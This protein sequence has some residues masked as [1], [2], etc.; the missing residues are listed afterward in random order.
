MV[1]SIIDAVSAE[2]ARDR[3]IMER[4][5]HAKMVMQDI[6]AQRKQRKETPQ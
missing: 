4:N 6:E 1:A 3:T 5:K 2:R